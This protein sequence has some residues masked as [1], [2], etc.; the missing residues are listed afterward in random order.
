MN[1]YIG[2]EIE[3]IRFEKEDIIVTSGCDGDMPWD[4]T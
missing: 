3:V 1:E 4:K 2:L